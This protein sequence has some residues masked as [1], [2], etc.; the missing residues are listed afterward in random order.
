MSTQPPP[1]E[2]K[3]MTLPEPPR[4]HH[5]LAVPDDISARAINSEAV[6]SLC[7][8]SSGELVFELDSSLRSLVAACATLG[9]K[10][11]LTLKLQVQPCGQGRVEVGYDI[12]AKEPKEKRHPSMLFSTAQGQLLAH[13]PSQMEMDLKVV[14]MPSNQHQPLRTVEPPAAQ[15]LKK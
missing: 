2:E 7:R 3:T 4:K 10:G 12:A 1:A 11:S 13:D 9:R 8:V 15:T 5:Y 14:P 6:H